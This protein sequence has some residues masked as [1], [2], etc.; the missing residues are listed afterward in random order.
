MDFQI[1]KLSKVLL[2]DFANLPDSPGLYFLIDSA[3]RCWYIGISETSLRNRHAK[4]EKRKL[5][6][7]KKCQWISFFSW[8]DISD[9]KEWEIESIKKFRPPLNE[10]YVIDELPLLNLGYCQTQ[11]IQRYKECKTMI[12]ALTKELEELKP[13]L[14]TLLEENDGK[15]KTDEYNAYIQTRKN[16][17]YSQ[18]VLN[19]REQ[20]KQL[21]KEEQKTGVATI[22]SLLTYP[23]VR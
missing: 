15:I 5:F 2:D 19:M 12:D 23:V 17:G 14:V 7:E 10:N 8:N 22:K 1:K 16:W 13:N 11:Y 6:K 9:I 21:E 20:L 4:H 3:V 18:T